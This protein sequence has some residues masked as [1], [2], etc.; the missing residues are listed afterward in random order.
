MDTKLPLPLPPP[1]S[2]PTFFR[3]L[4]LTGAQNSRITSKYKT[5][6][7]KLKPQSLNVTLAGYT[8]PTHHLDKL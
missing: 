1:P 8:L 7:T 4:L 6:R 2:Q 3:A 5:R